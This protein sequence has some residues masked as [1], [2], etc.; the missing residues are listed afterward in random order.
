M[1]F[2]RTKPLRKLQLKQEHKHER[3]NAEVPA[4]YCII[5]IKIFNLSSS[6][7]HTY[8]LVVK[9]IQNAQLTRSDY[10]INFDSHLQ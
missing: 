6:T 1:V 10:S 3:V 2:S 5:L 7:V 4:G 9:I 8:K